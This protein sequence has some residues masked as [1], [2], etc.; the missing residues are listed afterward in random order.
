MYTSFNNL[1]DESRVWIYQSDRKLSDSE[2]HTISQT[3]LAFTEQWEVHGMPME[4]SFEIRNSYFII[5]A[6]NDK[7]SGCSIDSSVRTIQ[8]I[9]TELGVDFFNR[10]LIAFESTNGVFQL[11]L[12]A[13]K[14]EGTKG[15]WSQSS[16]VYNLLADTKRAVM[17]Q[18]LVPAG[19]HW[20]QR[21]L[22]LKQMAD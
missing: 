2:I 4:A 13:L 19:S 12:V 3:L 22:P 9:G 7:A 11:P 17:Q 6:A 18:W 16:L 21:Y 8:N 5:L 1:P 20:I 15:T 10:S 14:S